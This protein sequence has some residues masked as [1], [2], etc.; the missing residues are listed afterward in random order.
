METTTATTSIAFKKQVI[1]D[2]TASIK[3]KQEQMRQIQLQIDKDNQTIVKLAEEV[4]CLENENKEHQFINIATNEIIPNDQIT[5]NKYNSKWFY[6]NTLTATRQQLKPIFSNTDNR[7]DVKFY[8]ETRCDNVKLSELNM[9]DIVKHNFTDYF[10]NEE[11]YCIVSKITDKQV[12]FIPL[13]KWVVGYEGDQHSFNETWYKFSPTNLALNAKP[14]KMNK[15]SSWRKVVSEN[16]IMKYTGD[17][18]NMY[19]SRKYDGG[20]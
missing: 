7:G 14:Y 13:V 16:E 5:P 20:A 4:I 2:L 10:R 6:G 18:N 3:S 19:S 8:V 12:Q 1:T 15:S 17:R 11:E 9:G